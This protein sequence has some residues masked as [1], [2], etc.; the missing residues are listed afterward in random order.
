M[1]SGVS[2]KLH[3]KGSIKLHGEGLEGWSRILTCTL[4]GEGLQT[5]ETMRASTE[6]GENGVPIHEFKY[7]DLAAML[8]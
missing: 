2:I 5:K 4:G 1:G 8:Q 6:A 7:F 3:G